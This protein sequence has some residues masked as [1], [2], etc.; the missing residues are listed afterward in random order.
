MSLLSKNLKYLRERYGYTQLQVAEACTIERS[1]YAYYESGKI[2]PSLRTLSIICRAY[3]VCLDEIVNHDFT[4][5]SSVPFHRGDPILANKQE[6]R[7]LF[8]F[9]MM[10]D[11]QRLRLI[12]LAERMSA[13]DI[14]AL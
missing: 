4:G 14:V 9:R 2:E 3:R 1:T 12:K 5:Q 7:L 10:D 11:C 8:F 13:R 6:I